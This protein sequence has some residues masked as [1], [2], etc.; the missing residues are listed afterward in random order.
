[1]NPRFIG[2]EFVIRHQTYEFMST[3]FYNMK[4]V[5]AMASNSP[6]L[7]VKIL[8]DAKV[9]EYP[10]ADYF[11]GFED[12]EAVKRIFGKETVDVLN[13]LVVE[14]NSLRRGYMGVSDT[15]GHLLINTWYLKNGDLLDI[16]LDVIHELVHVKQFMEGRDLFDCS[17]DYVDR[18]TEI[19][20]YRYAVEE[21]RRLGL[22]DKRICEYLRTEWVCDRDFKR[23]I[24]S[25]NVKCD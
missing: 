7:N 13:T 1:M 10:F 4:D 16:Y 8:R 15:S 21:A 11:K 24:D 2:F 22:S 9:Q 23:L 6:R 14:F 12:V 18:P 25:V 20:A 19:E 5:K 17:Y 3:P